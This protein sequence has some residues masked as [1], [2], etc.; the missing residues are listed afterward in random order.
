MKKAICITICIIVLLAVL[1]LLGVGVFIGYGPFHSARN[2][3]TAMYKGNAEQYDFDKIEFVGSTPLENKNVCV[4]GS[5][6]VY[7]YSSQEQSIAE[8]LT[9]RFGCTCTKEA[10][11]G[12]TLVDNGPLSYV[13]RMKR[14]DK[15]AHYDLF[16]CQLSTNDATKKK[17]LGEI[18]QTDEYDTSTVTGAM[19]YI[20]NYAADTW[21]CPVVFFT[22]SHYDSEEYD[23]MVSRLLELKEKY[24]IGVID[25]W[26]D[27]EFN[28]ITDEQRALYM[29][30]N[31]HP[32]KAG[33]RD[34]WGPEF[35]KQLFE[36]LAEQADN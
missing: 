36:Y 31:V 28:N 2:I 20:I 15:N 23:A 13:S 8:Y 25:L 7:G 35:E 3:L 24:G 22:G 10:V 32:T 16:I 21:H 30:D 9:K 29:S 17:P 27:E 4:L 14:K 5:S 11:S 6:V 26:T 12:T 1:A 33:Y 18:S 34:W 19:E